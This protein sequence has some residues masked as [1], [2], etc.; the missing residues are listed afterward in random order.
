MNIFSNYTNIIEKALDRNDLYKAEESIGLAYPNYR[1]ELKT[2]SKDKSSLTLS[3]ISDL[4]QITTKMGVVPIQNQQVGHHPDFIHLKGTKDTENHYILSA[5]IDIKNSTGLFRRYDNETIY[6]ITNTIQL[7]A[8]A[9]CVEFGGFIHRLQ[10]DGVFVYFG[11]KGLSEKDATIHTLTALSLFTYFVQN[12]LKKLFESRGIEAIHTTIGADLGFKK[13]V[14]WAMAGIGDMSEI[15]T[16][17]LHTSLASKMQ[18]YAK[19]N[20]IIVGNNV[21]SIVDFE[22]FFEVVPD[23]RYIFQDTARKFYYTQYIFKAIQYIK[24]RNYIVTSPLGKIQ[25]KPQTPQFP[26][27]TNPLRNIAKVNKPYRL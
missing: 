8:I 10:G 3:S 15:T 22:D 26:L 24:S 13:D 27:D 14:L 12:D 5:F 17:S 11:R 23:K 7:A 25:L 4:Q 16:Y 2:F 20:Q 21:K 18:R 9:I 6:M 1:Y 19:A